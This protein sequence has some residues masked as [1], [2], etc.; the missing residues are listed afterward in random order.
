MCR[1]LG[2]WSESPVALAELLGDRWESFVTLSQEHRD[3]WGMAWIDGNGRL[4][5]YKEPYPAYSSEAFRRLAMVR[6][7]AGLLH[8]RWA[9]PGLDVQYSNTHP[10]LWSE[11][12][13]AFAHNG[14]FT[15]IRELVTTNGMDAPD[16]RG[17]S[18]SEHYF[19]AWIRQYREGRDVLRAFEDV[20]VRLRQK[21][22][23]YTSLNALLLRP[24][25]LWVVSEYRPDA[26][27]SVERP[28]YYRLYGV[29][30]PLGYA[31]ASS[32]WPIPEDWTPIENHVV[33]QVGN[34][35]DRKVFGL[36]L[37]SPRPGG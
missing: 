37:K 25:G 14:S 22:F 30:T 3:G 32:E 17:T 15:P 10:F 34:G 29:Q 19:W 23:S 13:A 11:G 24:D 9:T 8:F 31:V 6:S 1:L 20:V 12:Q 4:Q 7:R 28:G 5:S 35:G 26:P 2:H 18:D 33:V 27:L 36:D 16:I 21:P